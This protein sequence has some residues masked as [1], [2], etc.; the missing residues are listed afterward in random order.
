M[1]SK[2][3]KISFGAALT[4]EEIRHTDGEGRADEEDDETIDGSLESLGH[5][6]ARVAS[7]TSDDGQV[8]GSGDGK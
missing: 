5:D 1:P 3:S 8:I 7:L 6:L 2:A 4:V